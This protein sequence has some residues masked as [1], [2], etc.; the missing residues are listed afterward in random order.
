[1]DAL[2]AAANRTLTE[3][4]DPAYKSTLSPTLDAFQSLRPGW[5]DSDLG[6]TLKKAW[7]VDP[8][9]TLRIIWNSRSIHD[10]KM[11]LMYTRAFGWLFENHPRTAISNLPQLIKPVCKF[12]K[13]E[14]TAPHGYW[15]DL[16]N[17][18]ALAVC[19]QLGPLDGPAP[20]LHSAPRWKSCLSD[21]TSRTPEE[22]QEYMAHQKREARERRIAKN[23]NFHTSLVEALKEPRIRAL[24]VTVAQLF[25]ERLVEDSILADRAASMSPGEERTAILRQI[26]L[27][28]KWAPSPGCSHDRVTNLSSAISLLIYHDP[29]FHL[30]PTLSISRDTPTT[31]LDTHILRSF[32]QRWILRPLREALSCAESLM[33]TNRWSEIQYRRV[34]SICMQRNLPNFYRHDPARFE[35]YLDDVEGGKA[36]ISGATLLP[37][38]LIMEAA[39]CR[40]DVNY[41][42]NPNSHNIRDFHKRV[43]ETKLRGIEAQWKVML[44]RVRE[45]GTLD[46][47]LAI[48]DVS[49]S[50]GYLSIPESRSVEPIFP[51]IA[52]TLVLTSCA[53]PPFANTFITFSAEPEVVR[54]DPAQTLV[55]KLD[56]MEKSA[57]GMNTAFDRV[58]LDLLLPLAVENNVR[59]E[60]M[61]K[62]LF[63]FSDMQ[64]DSACG[65]RRDAWETSHDV[66]ERKF[67]EAGYELPE[68]VYWNLATRETTHPVTHERKGVALMNGF[69]PA[70][71]KVFM[72]DAE[73]EDFE[74]IEA[75]AEEKTKQ[76]LDPINIML[77]AVSKESYS[78]L[79]VVD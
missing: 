9:V 2:K 47:C 76:K 33:S 30:R 27:A 52:L 71:L 23:S 37:H 70:M 73:E 53:R 77:K 36:K 51:A 34:P 72:G 28:G 43:A 46:N 49:G 20:F 54:L 18:V 21:R 6:D 74:M 66:I 58:L 75:S 59:P 60:D 3:N 35:K 24:Y 56:A 69:S 1:M 26:S 16:L 64:F 57:W 13:S 67:R 11:S 31:T 12:G 40:N 48:C 63:V 65:G 79:V 61:V 68:I 15:K 8:E 4:W 32:Y 42:P 25:A 45:A 44:D 17:V 22:H 78:G 7:A 14:V 19:R 50:M 5:F 29:A 55:Q 38:Q 41:T 39:K 10:G 62:R